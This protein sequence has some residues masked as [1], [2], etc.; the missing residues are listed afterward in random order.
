MLLHIEA[1]KSKSSFHMHLHRMYWHHFNDI[2]LLY[3]GDFY[4]ANIAM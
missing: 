3:K 4:L 2:A 1:M